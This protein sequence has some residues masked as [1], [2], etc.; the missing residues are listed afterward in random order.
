MA[1]TGEV[2]LDEGKV[3]HFSAADTVN[4]L[5]RFTVAQDRPKRRSWPHNHTRNP[6]NVG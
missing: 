6:G 5:A 3:E 1:T 2:R 4:W